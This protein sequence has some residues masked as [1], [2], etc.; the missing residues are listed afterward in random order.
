MKETA[1][2]L[3]IYCIL[4][5]LWPWWRLGKWWQSITLHYWFE[6]VGPRHS[7]PKQPNIR[8]LWGISRKKRNKWWNQASWLSWQSSVFLKQCSA[9]LNTEGIEQDYFY[10][11]DFFCQ[12]GFTWR[13]SSH[14]FY[15][16]PAYQILLL[17]FFFVDPLNSHIN[18]AVAMTQ[19]QLYKSFI[20]SLSLVQYSCI[21]K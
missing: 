6:E 10:S 12:R 7:W 9:S 18:T 15:L 17:G 20:G 4:F 21:V 13:A 2:S 14:C 19:I 3:S 8:L 1:R 16:A 11:N 5:M